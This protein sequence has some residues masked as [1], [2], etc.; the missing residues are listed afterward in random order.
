MLGAFAAAMRE[1][2]FS[3]P[4][5]EVLA[6]TTVRNAVSY[7]A[8]TFRDN[9]RGNPTLDEDGE[10]AR[11]LSR[12]YRA[13]RNT[14]PPVKQQKAIPVCVLK[15]LSKMDATEVQRATAELAIGGFFFAC[16]SCEYLKVPQAEKRRTDILRLRNICF[17]LDGRE[18][19]HDHRDLERADCV[20]ITFEKQKKDEKLD[21][22]TQLSSGDII[23]CPVRAWAA[24]VRRIRGYLGTN[25]DTPVSAVWRNGRLEDIT[26]TMLVN[27]LEGAIDAVGRDR[28]NIPKGDVGTHSIRSGA[29]M[30]M[31]LGEVPVYTIM[32][33][34]RWS[35]DA[36][37]RYIRKQVEMFSHN[38]SRKMIIHQFHRHV[39][40][41]ERSISRHDPRQ[42]N[43]P[44]NSQTRVNVGGDAA[45]RMRLPTLPLYN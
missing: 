8:A 7:V 26:S 44:Q 34:G 27:A 11:L 16:R 42:R 3:G 23:L 32:M 12:Q 20:S 25:G 5:Y 40:A 21:T 15:E 6:E 10:L 14:D 41:V 45:R 18:L 38:V 2:R 22:V 35:S 31:Y 17:F 9:D 36:F 39:P 37:L 13:Y 4:S 33:L 29:A 19:P 24:I 28:L 30:A 43:H 1:A